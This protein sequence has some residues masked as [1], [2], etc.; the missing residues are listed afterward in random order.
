MQSC[1]AIP[2]QS[3]ISDW[4]KIIFL[5]QF[6]CEY[7]K[8]MLIFWTLLLRLLF[9]WIWSEP[10]S[11]SLV[12]K[13]LLSSIIVII[14]LAGDTKALFTPLHKAKLE[15]PRFIKALKTPLHRAADV[16]NLEICQ[17]HWKRKCKTKQLMP[18]INKSTIRWSRT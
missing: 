9:F 12:L 7:E 17:V 13:R 16:G 10:G 3:I 14:I 4:Y 11:C 15:W 1:Y 18:N 8:Y 6:E 5:F 2:R